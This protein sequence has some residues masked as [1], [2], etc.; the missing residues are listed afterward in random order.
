MSSNSYD[1][2]VIG[3]GPGGCAAATYLAKAGHRVLVLEK[4]TFPRFRI[5]ES[6]LP[7][8]RPILEEMGVWAKLE[9]RGF[10]RKLGAQFHLGDGSKSLKFVFREGRFTRHTDVIQVERAVFDQVLFDHAASCGA[11]TRQGWTVQ[12]VED[13]GSQHEIKASTDAGQSE[14]LTARFVIDASGRANLTGT[15]ER[16]REFHPRL[17]KLALFG[18]FTGVKLDPGE[19]A[20]D[21]VIVRLK[22]KWFWLIPISPEKTSVGCVL[23]KEEFNARRLP[24]GDIL[25]ELFLLAAPVRER[26]AGAT[27]VGPVHTTTDFSYYNRKLVGN[28]LLRVGDAAGFMDP[29]FS[30]GVYLAMYSGKLAA[31]TVSGAL[32]RG[33]DGARQLARYEQKVFA[34]MKFYWELVEQFYTHPFMEV[35]MEPR[36]LWDI[37]AAVNAVLAGELDGGWKLRWRLRVFYW[38]IKLQGRRPF[39]PRI[40]FER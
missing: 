12:R 1:V 2:V 31:Q 7:Y 8:N 21:T 35:F 24:A 4:E 29:I 33:D 40:Q 9:G 36:P 16:L 26:M 5:G 28:R 17:R 34:G 20:G 23:D 14:T 25:H 39:L 27:L 32:K 6:L 38:L 3:G 37:P 15:Q 22:D 10:P 18:H 13:R 11:E 19:K 30:A